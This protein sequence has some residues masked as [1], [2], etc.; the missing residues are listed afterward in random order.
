MIIMLL[1]IHAYVNIVDKTQVL[2]SLKR[3]FHT[4]WKALNNV[5]SV[6]KV[7]SL[8]CLLTFL[9][10]NWRIST[11]ITNDDVIKWKQFLHY[12]P[13]VRWIHRS[14]ADSPHKGH[15]ALMLSLICAWTNC[16]ANNR[17]V[18]DLR[19]HRYH[20][21]VT[22]MKWLWAILIITGSPKFKVCSFVISLLFN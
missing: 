18:S 2:N 21:D 3:H 17:D 4:L 5:R 22:V 19:H 15:W 11:S 16:W 10:E 8:M 9:K 12:W 7:I 20:Y 1:L 13:F 14:P 6:P